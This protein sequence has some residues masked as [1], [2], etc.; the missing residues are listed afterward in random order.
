MEV[1]Q[2]IWPGIELMVREGLGDKGKNTYLVVFGCFWK[3]RG[4]ET[5]SALCVVC[6]WEF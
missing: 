5:S 3:R 1:R 6:K 4:E 2:N